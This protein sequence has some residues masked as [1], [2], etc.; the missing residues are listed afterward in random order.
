M[1]WPAIRSVASAAM[2]PKTP[3]AIDSGSIARSAFASSI[4]G[5]YTCVLR[6]GLRC[7]S[8]ASTAGTSRVAV[9]EHER[10][11]GR[12]D[13]ARCEPAT[14][15]RREQRKVRAHRVDVVLHDGVVVL[16]DPDE[17]HVHAEIRVGSVLIAARARPGLLRVRVEAEVQH[18]ADVEPEQ[19]RDRGRHDDFVRP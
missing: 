19:P 17:R 3:S 5:T 15:R 12:L 13:A 4:D 9:V 11:V 18:R 14:Q 10:S 16:T 6:S 2:S 8:S 1:S 7:V